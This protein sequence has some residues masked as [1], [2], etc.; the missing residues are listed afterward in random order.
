MYLKIRSLL[1]F[2]NM[3]KNIARP[4]LQCIAVQDGVLILETLEAD[5]NAPEGIPEGSTVL[6]SGKSCPAMSSNSR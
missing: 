4:Q 5:P 3:N 2:F 1:I 6:A